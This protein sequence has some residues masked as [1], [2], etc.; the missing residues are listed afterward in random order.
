V[1][2]GSS[3]VLAPETDCGMNCA[4]AAAE[5]CGGPNRLNVFV[6]TSISSPPGVNPGVDGWSSLG[7]YT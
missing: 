7:C 2:I 5:A 1:A 6:S 4:G 3:G